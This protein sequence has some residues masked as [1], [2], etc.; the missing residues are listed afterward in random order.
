M[1]KKAYYKGVDEGS[2]CAQHI[3]VGDGHGIRL[4][5]WLNGK[6]SAYGCRRCRFHSWVRKIPWRRK[7]QLTPVFLPG[8]LH[9]HWSLVD[10]SPRGPERAGHKRLNNNKT[11]NR[12][13]QCICT[14]YQ[15]WWWTWN[16]SC[17]ADHFM[18]SFWTRGLSLH[19]KFIIGQI[20]VSWQVPGPPWNCWFPLLSIGH[21]L[22]LFSGGQCFLNCC[23][24]NFIRTCKYKASVT[25][26]RNSKNVSLPT[27]KR[28]KDNSVL[29]FT[30]ERYF[31]SWVLNVWS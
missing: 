19:C 25:W 24:F 22:E 6:E 13:K 26:K 11:A 17:L 27:V 12:W 28:M 3:R 8:K 29:V 1:E 16:I 2:A 5:L 15:S 21:S 31:H 10:C 23:R 20:A 30:Y 4:P 18:Q 9:G 7:W 14:A